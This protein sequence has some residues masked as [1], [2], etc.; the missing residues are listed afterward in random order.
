MSHSRNINSSQ[1][2]LIPQLW[3]CGKFKELH[4]GIHINSVFVD[5]VRH[6]N[7]YSF[8]FIKYGILKII[9]KYTKMICELKLYLTVR[10]RYPF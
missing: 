10:I 2:F 4:F 1:S 5:E 8:K 6:S 3:N 9:F 7:I